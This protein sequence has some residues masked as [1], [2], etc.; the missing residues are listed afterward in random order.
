MGNKL[1]AARQ[2]VESLHEA[3]LCTTLAVASAGCSRS[4]TQEEVD[5]LLGV[6]QRSSA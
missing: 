1:P 4:L 5:Q 3:E 2:Y 6:H